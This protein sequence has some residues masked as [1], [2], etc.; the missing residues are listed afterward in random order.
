ML[1]RRENLL[2]VFRHEV[3]EWILFVGH[4]DPYNQPKRDGMDPE[5]T[6]ADTERVLAGARKYQDP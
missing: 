5:R 2:R 1:T 4:I 3:P 6:M